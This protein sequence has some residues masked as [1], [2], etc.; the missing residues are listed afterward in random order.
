MAQGGVGISSGQ[1]RHS[2][3]AAPKCPCTGNQLAKPTDRKLH[4]NMKTTVSLHGFSF[5]AFVGAWD[6]P[7]F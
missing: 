1:P 4:P 6:L 3:N 5:F 7:R 2:E